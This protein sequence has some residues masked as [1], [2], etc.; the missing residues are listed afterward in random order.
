MSP[1]ELALI[2]KALQYKL[3][4]G[5]QKGNRRA[6]FWQRIQQNRLDKTRLRQQGD[7]IN[8]LILIGGVLAVAYL[9]TQ[10]K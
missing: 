1:Q 9:V 2:D 10:K 3:A 6:K 7:Q 8:K 4:R 5:E